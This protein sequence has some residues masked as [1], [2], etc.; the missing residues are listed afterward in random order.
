MNLPIDIEIIQV[1]DINQF[2]NVKFK[3]ASK[4]IEPEWASSLSDSNYI[5]LN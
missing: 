2:G 5:E 3:F 1:K 4:D